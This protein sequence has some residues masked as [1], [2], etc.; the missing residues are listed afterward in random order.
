MKCLTEPVSRGQGPWSKAARAAFTAK[1]TSSLSPFATYASTSPV[2]GS[3]V[4]NVL[5][6]KNKKNN[7][8]QKFRLNNNNNN[9]YRDIVSTTRITDGKRN[10]K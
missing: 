8:K 7:N 5:P 2:L 1:S 6:S 10:R 4:S 3:I 9:Q